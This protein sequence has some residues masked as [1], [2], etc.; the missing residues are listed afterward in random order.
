MVRRGDVQDIK[1][2]FG[3]FVGGCMLGLGFGQL[4]AG[5]RV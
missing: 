2:W 5:L 1:R 4:C 3:D